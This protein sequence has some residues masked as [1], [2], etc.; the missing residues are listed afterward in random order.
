MLPI[1][2][3]AVT[4]GLTPRQVYRRVAAVR[5]LLA[6]YIRRGQNGKLLL[7][8]SAIEILRRAEELRKAG[9]TINEAVTKINDEIA[10]KLRGEVER[11][12]DELPERELWERLINEKDARIRALE[13]EIAFLRRRVEELTAQALPASRRRWWWP[14]RQRASAG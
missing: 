12:T 6:P 8:P 9:L 14:W 13:E 11:A 3:A 10:G 1:E 2:D 4:L 7:D 5:P